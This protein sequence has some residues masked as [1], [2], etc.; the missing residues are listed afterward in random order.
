MHYFESVLKQTK[1]RFVDKSCS[2]GF[3]E[4]DVSLIQVKII[5]NKIP[6]RRLTDTHTK[7]YMQNAKKVK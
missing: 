2:K 4:R 6:C 7:K 5:K 1:K 3:K